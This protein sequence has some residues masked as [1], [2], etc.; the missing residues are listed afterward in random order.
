MRLIHKRS[1]LLNRPDLQRDASLI[2]IATEDTYASQQYFEESTIFRNPRVHVLALPTEDHRSAPEHVL[3]RLKDYHDKMEQNNG[4]Q[5]DDEFWLM[6]D[7]DHWT[8][9]SH[10][11]NFK[12]VCGEALTCGFQLAHSNPSF[13]VWL[14]L[15]FIELDASEQFPNSGKV[16][17]RPKKILGGYNKNRLD[18]SRFDREKAATAA[19][20]AEKLDNA[21]TDRW[22]QQTGSHVYR[23]VKRLLAS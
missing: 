22:P 12:Q 14:L 5:D 19:A 4:L 3:N 15:H 21:S 18:L 7:T 11:A 13:E 1:R 2:V 20:R 23:L 8:Q 16:E 9:S 6:L 17:V 10:V